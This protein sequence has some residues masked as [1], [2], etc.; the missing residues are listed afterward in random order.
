MQESYRLME[1]KK[2][3]RAYGIRDTNLLKDKEMIMVND[4]HFLLNKQKILS[5]PEKKKTLKYLKPDF[6][7]EHKNV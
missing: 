6:G 7:K 3:L 4:Q 1:M 2:L 5:L